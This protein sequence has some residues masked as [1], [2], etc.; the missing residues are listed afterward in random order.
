VTGI[1]ADV[2]RPVRIRFDSTQKGTREYSLSVDLDIAEAVQA[3][4]GAQK[5]LQT[6]AQKQHAVQKHPVNCLHMYMCT[7]T[8]Q[9]DLY[10]C[11]I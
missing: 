2:G 7:C 5:Q 6:G 8:G 1:V 3:L 9:P 4:K 11:Y 10:I